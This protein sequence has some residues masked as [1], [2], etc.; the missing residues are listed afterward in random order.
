MAYYLMQITGT[1]EAWAAMLQRQE[2]RTPAIE[3]AVRALGGKVEQIWFCLGE[4]EMVGLAQLPDNL[5]TA[6]F[7]MAIAA[8]GVCKS[9]K[10]IPLLTM[11]EGLEAMKKA[12]VLPYTPITQANRSGA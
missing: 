5:S 9:I 2:D 6:A 12:A 3:T 4:Y 8:G 11:Q 10:T 1:P 7:S